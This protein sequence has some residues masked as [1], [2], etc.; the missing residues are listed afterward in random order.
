MNDLNRARFGSCDHFSR[1]THSID[2]EPAERVREMARVLASVDE[3]L[4]VTMT[5]ERDHF[6][7]LELTIANMNNMTTVVFSSASVTTE[8]DCRM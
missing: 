5:V 2:L 1:S 6:L 3:G 8:C 7:L 4:V